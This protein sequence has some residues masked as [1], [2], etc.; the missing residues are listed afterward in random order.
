MPTLIPGSLFGM[1]HYF[2][3]NN[4]KGSKVFIPIDSVL[5]DESN[6]PTAN[7]TPAHP[8][9]TG[10]E[11][12]YDAH[13]VDPEH[14]I[15]LRQQLSEK[16]G[17][18]EIQFFSEQLKHE[19]LQ[20]AAKMQENQ[21]RPLGRDFDMHKVDVN[22]Q[23]RLYEEAQ[24]ASKQKQQNQLKTNSSSAHHYRERQN[25][26]LVLGPTVDSV[27]YFG[28][29]Q[30]FYAP[31][32]VQQQGQ[33]PSYQYQNAIYH[34]SQSSSQLSYPQ[35]EIAH[36]PRAG[37]KDN[38]QH[39]DPS[40]CSNAKGHAHLQ[41]RKHE[42]EAIQGPIQPVSDSQQQQHHN[43]KGHG[44]LQRKKHQYEAVPGLVQR[45]SNS[46][47]QQY[48]N[49][50][51]PGPLQQR[52]HQYETIPQPVRPVS[53]S[54]QQQ[55][56]N[57]KGPGP[58]QER[59]HQYETIPGPVQPISYGQQQQHQNHGS[60]LVNLYN[61]KEGSMILYG[62]TPAHSGT[63]KWIGYLPEENILSAGIEMVSMK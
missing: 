61:L 57:V 51:G 47:Q 56:H 31:Q 6:P 20:V 1:N 27:S 10:S 3:L 22:E 43:V 36:L 38:L 25:Q 29:R 19:N 39:H 41:Q 33:P 53:N 23:I 21:C 44:P 42:Y 46:Q 49:V 35:A 58:L 9:S 37:V 17:Q 50:K 45:V 52:E 24:H 28:A 60:N 16:E 62:D 2:T 15:H 59:Q 26:Q 18:S 30:Q 40:N 54:Q 63:I 5:K 48:Y 55:H 11:D 8:Y 13:K 32:V 12:K 34:Q 7:S 14:T 4:S